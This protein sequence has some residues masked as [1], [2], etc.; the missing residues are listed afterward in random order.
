MRGRAKVVFFVAQRYA[1]G[2]ASINEV[3]PKLTSDDLDVLAE[4]AAW[5]FS[6]PHT[7]DG[8]P[9]VMSL[10][11]KNDL[12]FDEK[13]ELSLHPRLRGDMEAYLTASPQAREVVRRRLPVLVR[14]R[15][16]ET[17]GATTR[18]AAELE[19]PR[20]NIYRMLKRMVEMGPIHGLLPHERREL[21]PSKARDGLDSTV[22]RLMGELLA[23]EPGASIAKVE[24]YVRDGVKRLGQA[25]T[26]IE[27]PSSSA[28]KRRLHHL[29]GMAVG[30]VV[31][32]GSVGSRL[33]IEHCRLNVDVELNPPVDGMPR[34]AS[35]IVA[36][37]EN[38][39]LIVGFGVFL[40]DA[41]AGVASLV[42]DA[43]VRLPRLAEMGAPIAPRM[44]EIDWIVPPELDAEC[45][46][47][48]R[49]LPASRRPL[50]EPI[51][52]GERRGGSRLVSLVGDHLDR[53]MLL[54]RPPNAA[55]I[56]RAHVRFM[57]NV[58]GMENA[59]FTVRLAVE[60]WNKGLLQAMDAKRRTNAA[61]R[62][63]AERLAA[64]L[65]ILFEPVLGSES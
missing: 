19:T 44:R 32:D 62:E 16:D 5:R 49:D 43:E 22:E 59:V 30:S 34:Y 61:G 33:L 65:R 50:V 24:R 14:T 51:T 6:P 53:L 28:I 63:P 13:N 64:D 1:A 57:Y 10:D 8:E 18:A 23:I 36:V 40:Q 27:P 45:E 38:T 17:R 4:L 42:R 46:L 21:A 39:K 48:G 31:S 7:V 47:V 35:M 58:G 52:H 60:H 20:A 56:S 2:M 3:S 37:D 12:A 15:Y 55:P 41:A 54:T 29:R 26:I 9:R 25:G 11:E